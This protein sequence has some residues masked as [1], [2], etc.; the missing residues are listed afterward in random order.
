VEEKSTNQQHLDFTGNEVFSQVEE[1]WLWINKA[2]IC[3]ALWGV[4]RANGSI[5]SAWPGVKADLFFPRNRHFQH[6]LEGRKDGTEFRILAL[7]PRRALAPQI[8]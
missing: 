8:L 6:L 1:V 4:A 5:L 3:N 7:F 2:F